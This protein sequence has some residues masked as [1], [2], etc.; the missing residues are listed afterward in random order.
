IA[1]AHGWHGIDGV[2][3]TIEQG[4][5]QQRMWYLA[6]PSLRGGSDQDVFGTEMEES[7]RMLGESMVDIIPVGDEKDMALDDSNDL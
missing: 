1:R 2:Q 3:A 5:A 6:D 4:L 7:T